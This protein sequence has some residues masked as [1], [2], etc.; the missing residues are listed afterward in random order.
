MSN[1]PIVQCIEIYTAHHLSRNVQF[2]QELAGHARAA[3]LLKPKQWMGTQ[4]DPPPAPVAAALALLKRSKPRGPARPLPPPPDISYIE[5]LL[6]DV[7]FTGAL[8]DMRD[9]V[10]YDMFKLLNILYNSITNQD[11]ATG[12]A[13]L[14]YIFSIKQFTLADVTHPEIAPVVKFCKNDVIWYLWWVAKAAAQG[15][16]TNG[17]QQFVQ[18]NFA[19]FTSLYQKKHRDARLPILVHTIRSVTKGG[20]RSIPAPEPTAAL[21]DLLKAPRARQ[22]HAQG[23][24]QGQTQKHHHQNQASTQ[25]SEP[26]PVLKYEY[27]RVFTYRESTAEEHAPAPPPPFLQAAGPNTDKQLHFD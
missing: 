13:I 4:E 20:L 15:P 12:E 19:L 25:A 10:T 11:A 22:A 24:G 8:D 23:Q 1:N 7:D 18:A 16:E 27:L 5:A 6:S 2:A 9:L 17:H 14:A 21:H 3:A 26:E